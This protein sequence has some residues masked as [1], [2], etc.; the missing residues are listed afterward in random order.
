[1]SNYMEIPKL[2]ESKNVNSA[3]VDLTS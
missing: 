1:L 2:F 3:N